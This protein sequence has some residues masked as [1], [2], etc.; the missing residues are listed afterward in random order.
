MYMAPK[1]PLLRFFNSARSGVNYAQKRSISYGPNLN[2]HDFDLARQKSPT[3]NRQFLHVETQEHNLR[4]KISQLSPEHDIHK[5]SGYKEAF[6]K[7]RELRIEH[8]PAVAPHYSP[9]EHKVSLMSPR[10]MDETGHEMQHAVDM[11]SGAISRSNP[12]EK[13]HSELR[14]FTAQEKI[15][16]ELHQ[17]S[18]SPPLFENRT[19][20]EMAASY[21]GK[22]SYP[23]TLKG[24]EEIVKNRLGKRFRSLDELLNNFGSKR[25]RD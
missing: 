10:N 6:L 23:G 20:Q 11:M 3:L 22:D 7:S 2:V 4:Q 17:T 9:L 21:H 5:V 1:R 24:S 8:D 18:A 19:P 15:H 25:N 16:Q 12:K 13:L 14:A